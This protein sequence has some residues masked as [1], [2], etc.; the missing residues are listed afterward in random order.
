LN[1]IAKVPFDAAH[2][3]ELHQYYYSPASFRPIRHNSSD[4]NDDHR[5]NGQNHPGS[6]SSDD[7]N[8]PNEFR[9]RTRGVPNGSSSC[10][11]KIISSSQDVASNR[12]QASSSSSSSSPSQDHYIRPDIETK[13]H[14]DLDM[15]STTNHSRKRQVRYSNSPRIAKFPRI[16]V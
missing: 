13:L 8:D 15:I 6:L 9:H 14:M 3:W 16:Q 10:K 12:L 11:R 7:E 2:L 4:Q 1:E 5:V